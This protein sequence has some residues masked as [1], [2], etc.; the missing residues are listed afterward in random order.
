MA[1]C[2]RAS[3]QQRV[4]APPVEEVV[5]AQVPVPVR[6]AGAVALQ[7]PQQLQPRLVLREVV[8]LV[9]PRQLLPADAARARLLRAVVEEATPHTIRC[10]TSRSVLD[11]SGLETRDRR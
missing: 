11:A 9:Q 1:S 2:L 10:K 4:V 3:A 6:V 8:L 5:V 7:Q